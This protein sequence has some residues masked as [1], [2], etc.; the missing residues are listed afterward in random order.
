MYY[1]L[2]QLCFVTNQGKRCYKLGQQHYY[3]LGQILLQVEAPTTN[4]GNLYY[5]IGQLLQTGAKCITNWGRYYKLGQLLQLGRNSSRDEFQI[6][7]IFLTLATK[8]EDG[9]SSFSEAKVELLDQSLSDNLYQSL[10]GFLAPFQFP[11]KCL[12]SLRP[13]NQTLLVFLD[14]AAIH[15]F[16]KVSIKRPETLCGFS[17]VFMCCMVLT[18]FQLLAQIKSLP[19]FTYR[20]IFMKF[21]NMRT[22]IKLLIFNHFI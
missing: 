17:I 9:D 14:D 5:K 13:T 10:S 6:Q 19:C 3:K 2:G 15:I 16:L 20:T 1:K 22:F 7:R 8:Q 11:L 12:L 18:N 21:F 4:Q